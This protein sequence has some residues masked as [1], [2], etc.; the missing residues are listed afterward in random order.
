MKPKVTPELKEILDKLCESDDT[1]DV[2]GKEMAFTEWRQNVDEILFNIIYVATSTKST[3]GV[4]FTNIHKFLS[5]LST[6]T[7]PLE[8]RSLTNTTPVMSKTSISHSNANVSA[9]SIRPASLNPLKQI[10][11]DSISGLQKGTMDIATANAISS[12]VDQLINIGRTEL[13]F[14]KELSKIR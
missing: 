11:L 1:H 10:I 7:E 4:L 9:D 6:N 13:E 5:S 2:E 14:M 12:Q 3:Y 8:K